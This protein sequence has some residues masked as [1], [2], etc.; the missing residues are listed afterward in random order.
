MRLTSCPSNIVPLTYEE[1]SVDANHPNHS[2]EKSTKR[3]RTHFVL[4]TAESPN[5]IILIASSFPLRISS[6]DIIVCYTIQVV[7]RN[8]AVLWM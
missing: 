8:L 5:K 1:L 4:P 6:S 7:N 2:S 3:K